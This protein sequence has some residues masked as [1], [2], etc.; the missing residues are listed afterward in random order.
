MPA[1][2]ITSIIIIGVFTAKF[3]YPKLVFIPV[4][5]IVLWT[6]FLLLFTDPVMRASGDDMEKESSE[7]Y[8]RGFMD[9]RISINRR[10]KP[11]RVIAFGVVCSL[12]ISTLIL[13][14]Y[15]DKLHT[16]R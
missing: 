15:N 11:S 8:R 6:S 10:L 3:F 14:S 12:G 7:D 13:N 2:I 5:I 9:G 4:F 1:L 16:K